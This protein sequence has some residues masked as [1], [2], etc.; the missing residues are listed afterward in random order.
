MRMHALFMI[1]K[2]VFDYSH[3][4]LILSSLCAWVFKVVNRIFA[5]M[6]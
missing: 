2:K 6:Y 5:L 4:F 1:T 3:A